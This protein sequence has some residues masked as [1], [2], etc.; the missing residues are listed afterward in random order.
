M[1]NDASP[2]HLVAGWV[3]HAGPTSTLA[4]M[5]LYEHALARH[6]RQACPSGWAVSAT[7]WSRSTFPPLEAETGPPIDLPPP[8]MP[9]RMFSSRD[10]D[11]GARRKFASIL[12][13]GVHLASAAA[14]VGGP[15]ELGLDVATDLVEALLLSRMI[16]AKAN[17][18]AEAR[19]DAVAAYG[20]W[21]RAAKQPKHG[22]LAKALNRDAK[23][24]RLS[25]LG[26]LWQAWNSCRWGEHLSLELD[27][28]ARRLVDHLLAA[29]IPRS[30]L[31]L[32]QERDAAG[33][34]PRVAELRLPRREVDPRPG[35]PS[36]RLQW[37]ESD[38]PAVEASG[39]TLSMMGLHW[40]FVVLGSHLLA[41]G[42]L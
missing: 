38:T 12:A 13:S 34:G 30:A 5:H 2:M 20:L 10:L 37:S 40:H 6:A 25:E 17:W 7:A 18:T 36:V 22:P 26:T 9:R 23:E 33:L 16:D 32:V 14:A 27:R 35:R 11:L 28:P 19:C 1:S 39:A 3:G 41:S 8:V 15:A 4:Y 42:I 31:L 21:A 24:G 29:G